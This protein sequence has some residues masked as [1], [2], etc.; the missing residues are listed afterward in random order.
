[1]RLAESRR[2]E[3]K[4]WV[5]GLRRLLGDCEARRV[6][7]AVALTDHEP[8]ER[9]ARVESEFARAPRLAC[10]RWTGLRRSLGG[11]DAVDELHLER[12]PG[13]LRRRA[14][15]ELEIARLDPLAGLG[16]SAH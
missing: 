10:G 13:G 7:E 6:G 14:V 2:A 12:A 15:Q 1:M 9:V 11:A 16:G 3:K 4:E 8:V 5:V